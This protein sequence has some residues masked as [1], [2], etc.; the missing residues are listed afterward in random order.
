MNLTPNLFR[1]WE[2]KENFLKKSSFFSCSRVHLLQLASVGL[3]E[4]G[5]NLMV[6]MTFKAHSHERAS[7]SNRSNQFADESSEEVS[8]HRVRQNSE[9]NRTYDYYRRQSHDLGVDL[10]DEETTTCAVTSSKKAGKGS[11]F[12]RLFILMHSFIS[13]TQSDKI[14]A[15]GRHYDYVVISKYN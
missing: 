13:F 10:S 2:T 7:S 8:G 15:N 4:E 11:T 6:T 9:C 5:S 3:D 12:F 14:Y 1:I